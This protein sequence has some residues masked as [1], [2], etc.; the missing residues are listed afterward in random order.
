MIVFP[1][2]HRT[3]P[4]NGDSSVEETAVATQVVGDFPVVQ[5]TAVVETV[6]ITDEM[7]N[8]K[9]RQQIAQARLIARISGLREKRRKEEEEKKKKKKKK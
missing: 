1:R 7:K 5:P 9:V 4:K 3:K 2:N 8:V 6:T